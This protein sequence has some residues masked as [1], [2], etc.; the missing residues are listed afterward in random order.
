MADDIEF[1]TWEEVEKGRIAQ[2][3]IKAAQRILDAA[4][5]TLDNPNYKRYFNATLLNVHNA[6]RFVVKDATT[7]EFMTYNEH[8]ENMFIETLKNPEMSLEQYEKATIAFRDSFANDQLEI[9]QKSRNGNFSHEE[10]FSYNQSVEA[11]NN[12]ITDGLEMRR[13]SSVKFPQEFYDE[14][15]TLRRLVVNVPEEFKSGADFVQDAVNT[16][17][18][19][20]EE[21]DGKKYFVD[22]KGN[23]VGPSKFFSSK[24]DLLQK[25]FDKIG[26][27]AELLDMTDTELL[28]TIK[29]GDYQAFNALRAKRKGKVNPQ[30]M[31]ALGDEH[32]FHD[33]GKILNSADNMDKT[34][35]VDEVKK[36]AK[37]YSDIA[38]TVQ[39]DAGGT[40]WGKSI[41]RVVL[42]ATPY[43]VATQSTFRNWQSCMHTTGCNWRYVDDA[44]GAGSIVAYGYNSKNPQQMISRYLIH[45]YYD[46]DGNVAYKV[47]D[48]VYGDSHGGFRKTIERVTEHFNEGKSGVFHLANGLYNDNGGAATLALLKRDAE[49]RIILDEVAKDGK[50]VIDNNYQS[51]IGVGDKFIISDGLE[52]EFHGVNI[53]DGVDFRGCKNLTLNNIESVGKDVKLPENITIQ[54]NI[55]D[56]VDFRGCKNLTLNNIE[57]IGEDVK[58]PEHVTFA[59]NFP[60]NI[61]LDEVKQVTFLEGWGDWRKPKLHD[62]IV[63]SGHINADLSDIKNLTLKGNVIFHG[64]T[65]LPQDIKY[66][67]VTIT[68]SFVS[69]NIDINKVK[70]GK[71]CSMSGIIPDGTDLSYIDNMKMYSVTFGKDVKLPK[72]V[73]FSE[74]A[75]ISGHIPDGADLSNC[76]NLRLNNVDYAGKG[77]KYPDSAIVSGTIPNG[78]DLSNFKDI[79]FEGNVTLGKGVKLPE[80]VSFAE[81]AT[82]SGYIPDNMDLSKIENLSLTGDITFGKNVRLPEKT[83]IENI[84][85]MSGYIPDGMHVKVDQLTGD[86]WLGKKL[87]YRHG[88]ISNNPPHIH[89]H[90]EYNWY[91]ENADFS[92]AESL[93]FSK[94]SMGEIHKDF[95]FP[96]NGKVKFEGMVGVDCPQ[97][98]YNIAKYD[99]GDNIVF[100]EAKEP[101]SFLPNNMNILIA[102]EENGEVIIEA[103]YKDEQGKKQLKETCKVLVS[104]MEKDGVVPKLNYLPQEEFAKQTG[105]QFTEVKPQKQETKIVRN[106]VENGSE[107]V[108][109]AAVEQSGKAAKNIA[110]EGAELAADATVKTAATKAATT[111]TEKGAKSGVIETIKA[112]DDKVNTAID[113]TIEKG[114]EKLNNTKVG[115]AYTKAEK[116]VANSTVG[117]AVNKGVKKVGSAVAKT[118]QKTGDAV[119]KTA[120]GKAV[121]KAAAKTA[122]KTAAKAVGKSVLK[123]IPIVSVGAG[124][125]FGAQRVMAGDWKGAA[126]EVAS[127]ALGTFPGVGTAASV[128]IDATLAGRDIYNEMQTGEQT[129]ST[130]QTGQEKQAATKNTADVKSQMRTDAQKANEYLTRQQQQ[131]GQTAK[132]KAHSSLKSAMKSDAQ[133]AGNKY[134]A[135]M[136][137]LIK[138]MNE[139]NGKN[140]ALDV[141][142]TTAQLY[143]KYGDSAYA[144]LQEAISK[145]SSCIGAI[146]S[147]KLKTSRDVVQYLCNMQDNAQNRQIVQKILNNRRQNG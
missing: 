126:G 11:I 141:M 7:G 144:L 12:S 49:G 102:R 21:I 63:I 35:F 72:V 112:V 125:V 31:N 101:I 82:I 61:C 13:K 145:P 124:L 78:T 46:K 59:N 26:D 139:A 47:N 123:K 116:A 108:A 79:N 38:K 9:A 113:K 77:I 43:D 74:G 52:V 8:V 115:K 54:G 140:K 137:D 132:N 27:N 147:N 57:S 55:P 80:N 18:V 56:G 107:N 97:T 40:S 134:Q 94:N 75:E 111:A 19:R 103:I 28:E 119:A 95:I 127:G 76:K 36:L 30:L 100:M 42:S 73:D 135:Q 14:N 5:I 2:R 110:I 65:R 118:V 93:T 53:P 136:E 85:T 104:G 114:S 131:I 60:E 71:G 133:N 16:Y 81:Y 121:K 69:K 86:V 87:E 25:L 4:G 106:A 146:N 64:N 92:K 130:A 143:Q 128:A 34:T 50:V 39:V 58:L 48:R 88:N 84:K 129:P 90:V 68:D 122:G 62:G 22:A 10:N 89:G 99:I 105:V 29:T 41:D 32:V 67:N 96:E 23:A 20:F 98:V 17:G 44:I 66:D 6:G 138:A 117:K 15:G 51:I 33:V 120:A 91:L 70:I 83:N 109:N 24:S 37:R 45:P 1:K 3:N 142:K